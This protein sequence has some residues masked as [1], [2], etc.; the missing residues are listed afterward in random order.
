MLP[1]VR[2]HAARGYTDMAAVCESEGAQVTFNFTPVLLEQIAKQTDAEIADEF[3][4]IS[5]IPI[6]DLTE[7]ERCTVLE[8]FFSVNWETQVRPLPRYA[9]LL[10]HRGEKSNREEIRRRHQ[11]F[12]DSDILDL[13]VLF[14]LAWIGFTGRKLP[15]VRALLQKGRNFTEEDRCVVLDVHRRMLRSVIPTYRKLSESGV[16]ELSTS[17][18]AHPILPLLCNSDVASP[19][20]PKATLPA[21]PYQYPEDARGQL[22][23][24]RE[25]FRTHFGKA[26]EGLWPSEGS[27]SEMAMTFAAG[28]GFRWAA[29]D[30]ENLYRSKTKVEHPLDPFAPFK[31]QTQE[32]DINLF[33]RERRLSDAIGFQY[34][35]RPTSESIADFCAKLQR[36]ADKTEGKPNRCVA[37]ILDG[38]NPWEYF[39][40]GGEAFL[41]G[42]YRALK[43][44]SKL[45]LSTFSNH[46]SKTKEPDTIS[47]LHAG[48]WIDA[49]FHIWIGDR[50]KNRAWDLLRKMRNQLE[51]QGKEALTNNKN[52]RKALF[53][54]EGSDWFWW[55]GE[56]FHSTFEPE[57]DR[58][59]RG[60]LQHA[61]VEAKLEVPS[62]LEMP[63]AAP[64]MLDTSNQPMFEMT[65]TLDGRVTSFYEWVG[66]VCVDTR[67]F[68]VAMGQIAR[69]IQKIHYGFDAKMLH[70]RIDFAES[71]ALLRTPPLNI[72]VELFGEEGMTFTWRLVKDVGV[73]PSNISRVSKRT[74]RDGVGAEAA[75]GDIVEISI[76]F[77]EVGLVPGSECSFAVEIWDGKVLQERLPREGSLRFRVLSGEELA[78]NWTI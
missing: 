2:L 72:G 27:I 29:S 70:L 26:P 75:I 3:E 45:C 51:L 71:S 23:W 50:E 19:A 13:T 48:S 18:F 63:V 40:D 22:E 44:D 37:V 73:P 65:P 43:S 58:L 21:T 30:E 55:F 53:F 17:P 25:S 69:L 6:H 54:A 10:E 34:G 11:K 15:E 36:I 59:F 68:G 42:L 24:A 14:H 67:R 57:F 60:F 39:S 47:A 41:S 74:T 12:S 33:F 78:A 7:E 8:H 66:A 56:P 16:A 49:N 52:V 31:F 76:P 32:G 5:R 9:E 1:W 4:R 28:S 77:G 61:L 64:D 35:R 38:E 46:L 20:L 62:I